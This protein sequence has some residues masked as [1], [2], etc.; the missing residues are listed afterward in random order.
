MLHESSLYQISAVNIEFGSGI[1]YLWRFSL[2]GIRIEYTESASRYRVV[3][4]QSGA[5]LQRIMSERI[6][7]VTEEVHN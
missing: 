5:A 7:D 1:R 2:R 6:V 3:K 4:S